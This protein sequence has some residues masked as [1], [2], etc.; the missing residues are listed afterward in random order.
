MENI[1]KQRN[2]FSGPSGVSGVTKTNGHERSEPKYHY[3]KEELTL[4]PTP[5]ISLTS[6]GSQVTF[7]GTDEI[8]IYTILART[9]KRKN[10]NFKVVHLIREDKIA[11]LSYAE[12]VGRKLKVDTVI[13][14]ETYKKGNRKVITSKYVPS[15]TYTLAKT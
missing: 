4:T 2:L 12:S 15:E 11:A 10:A 13:V 7:A 1:M 14:E 5:Q 6:R 3:P 8:T 9:S